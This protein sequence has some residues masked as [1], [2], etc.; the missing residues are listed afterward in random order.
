MLIFLELRMQ[1]C[2]GS[3]RN[4]VISVRPSVLFIYHI[5]VTLKML[6]T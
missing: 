6:N 3:A 1:I 4:C 5:L 2:A